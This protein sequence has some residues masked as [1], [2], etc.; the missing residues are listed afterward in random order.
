[1]PDEIERHCQKDP[2]RPRIIILNYPNN[3]SGCSYKTE[4]LK[5]IARVARKCA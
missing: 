1:M 5:A 2:E 4:E 3:P